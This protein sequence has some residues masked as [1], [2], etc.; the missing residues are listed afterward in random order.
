MPPVAAV[1]PRVGVPSIGKRSVALSPLRKA[2]GRVKTIAS[3][4]VE[5]WVGVA[6][7]VA[8][9]IRRALAVNDN[10]VRLSDVP[11]TT[12]VSV[13]ETAVLVRSGRSAMK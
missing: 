4:P 11:R 7:I 8:W 1:T 13:P 9:L 6:S 5:T 2:R 10:C 3:L 12:I